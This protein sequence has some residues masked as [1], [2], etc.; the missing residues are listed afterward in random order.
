MSI[1]VP[2]I[3][4]FTEDD[5]LALH[6]T[7][8]YINTHIGMTGPSGFSTNTGATGG[9]G[10]TGYTGPIG[11]PGTSS[12]TGSTGP[13]GNNGLSITGPTGAS[14]TGPTGAANVVFV[15]NTM[16]MSQI[17]SIIAN[18][19]NNNIFFKPGIYTITSAILV[20]R[21]NIILDGGNGANI[22]LANDINQPNFAVG[23]LSS[24][25]PTARI[26][27]V[28]IKNFLIDGN[29]AQQSSEFWPTKPWVPSSTMF[30]SLVTHFIWENCHI[31][32]ARSG[33]LTLTFNCI[34]CVVKDIYSTGH[35]FD[36]FTWYGSSEIIIQNC[37]GRDCINGAGI[38]VDNNCTY[39]SVIGCCFTNNRLG[40]F[41]RD[42]TDFIFSNNQISANYEQGMFLSGY[43]YYDVYDRGLKRFNISNNTLNNNGRQ[44]LYFQSC[45][46]F[47][48]N[49][50]SI[51]NNS[52]NG[53]VIGNDTPGSVNGT[54]N[55]NNISSNVICNNT[56]AGT[57]GIY[58]DGSNS[59]A[60]ATG[61]VLVG[62]I[63][64]NNFNGNIVGDLSSFSIQD[65]DQINAIT[66]RGATGNFGN[67]QTNTAYIHSGIIDSISCITGYFSNLT[68]GY[69]HSGIMNIANNLKLNSGI[70][71]TIL[72]GGLTGSSNFYF[73]STN[74]LLNNVL[75]TDGSGF[76]SWTSKLIQS[77]YMYQQSLTTSVST[78]STAWTATTLTKTIYPQFPSS[79]FLITINGNLSITSGG[80]GR[81]TIFANSFNLD[82]TG[83]GFCLVDN[84]SMSDNI[85][86]SSVD[87][88]GI[89]PITYTLYLK[90][91]GVGTVTFNK[92]LTTCSMIIQEIFQ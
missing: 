35:Y 60:V 71:T 73:P 62:N 38:S 90:T 10:P 55:Y 46:Y 56:G 77:T 31:K 24:N 49:G 45:N 16:S 53:I 84:I 17:N 9:L 81:A 18:T 92:N 89:S 67:L 27:N 32:D 78:L 88:P 23:D 48:V 12:S 74:G 5:S 36:H 41:A 50:N 68:G 86:F 80:I 64:K 52:N 87:V 79:Q 44:G 85:S 82:T 37:Y 40:V 34:D 4:T 20:N 25:T 33:G 19:N 72:S 61:N 54:C 76:T 15:N 91:N 58:I 70:N 11:L 59:S 42:C 6:Y 57:V 13:T 22:V 30:G 21:S 7:K 69:I 43:G 1:F 14:F 2:T 39:C 65:S 83:N 3:K 47:T 29:K 51:C 8:Y 28:T 75:T 66:I 63:I 26:S